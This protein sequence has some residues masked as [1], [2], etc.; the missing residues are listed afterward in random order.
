MTI[1]ELLNISGL[2]PLPLRAWLSASNEGSGG[3]GWTLHDRWEGP[4]DQPILCGTRLRLLD[5]GDG[6]K[7]AGLVGH[8]VV[9]G[10]GLE[11]LDEE[12]R[13][14]VYLLNPADPC[15]REAIECWLQRKFITVRSG[16]GGVL[17]SG[18]L[19]EGATVLEAC[20]YNEGDEIISDFVT[21]TLVDLWQKG[22]LERVL[23]TRL[24]INRPL[25][26]AI[27][28]TPMLCASLR[29]PLTQEEVEVYEAHQA[30]KLMLEGIAS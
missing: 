2:K 8:A 9:P 22:Q 19:E 13:A 25:L 7:C 18:T 28:E 26:C 10:D 24:G 4:G 11:I 30:N 21:C 17:S 23:R 5:L 1:D 29:P 6:L 15:V 16:N 12:E 27:V 20:R 3:Y 14:F